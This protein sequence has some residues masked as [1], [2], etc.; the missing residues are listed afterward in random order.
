MNGLIIRTPYIDHILLGQKDWEIRGTNTKIRGRIALIR[1]GHKEIC[2]YCDLVDVI[3]PLG[4]NDMN[5]NIH[6]H[7]SGPTKQMPYNKT[8]AWVMKNP[9]ILK[10]PKTYTHPNGAVIWVKL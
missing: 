3:G 9:K 4:K 10:V 7:H 5:N 2:G 8:Y 1:S 6:H